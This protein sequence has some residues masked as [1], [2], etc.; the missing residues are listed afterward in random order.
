M[1]LDEFCRR[2]NAEMKRKG[3]PGQ[4]EAASNRSRRKAVRGVPHEQSKDMEP[5]L[6]SQCR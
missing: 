6:L 1:W 5:R 2:Q 3:W 4:M